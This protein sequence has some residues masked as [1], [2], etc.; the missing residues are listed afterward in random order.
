[1]LSLGDF[2]L[3]PRSEQSVCAFL[4]GYSS[5]LEEGR[6]NDDKLKDERSSIAAQDRQ[7]AQRL[8]SSSMWR[9]YAVSQ[10]G[11]HDGLYLL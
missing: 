5:R 2:E 6:M 1:M 4:T 3:V 8:R 10:K 9:R 7:H 11:V